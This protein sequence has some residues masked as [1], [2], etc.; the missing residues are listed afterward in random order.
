MLYQHLAS[1]LGLVTLLL[2]YIYTEEVSMLIA[3][4]VLANIVYCTNHIFH[5]DLIVSVS[6]WRLPHMSCSCHVMKAV[7]TDLYQIYTMP[8]AIQIVNALHHILW[9]IKSILFWVLYSI[10]NITYIFV[11]FFWSW[12]HV[13]LFWLSAYDVFW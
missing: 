11:P 6:L 10:T 9:L 13:E 2:M 5:S 3:M 4:H 8:S 12:F 1:N 7:Y